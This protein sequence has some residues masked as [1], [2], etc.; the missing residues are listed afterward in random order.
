MGVTEY[1]MNGVR[2]A[3]IPISCR[4]E[5]PICG[6]RKGRC[7]QFINTETGVIEKIR[8]KYRESTKPSNGWYIHDLINKNNGELT[9]ANQLKVDVN[10]IKE[11]IVKRE[12]SQEDLILWDKVYRKMRTSFKKII[13]DYLYPEHKKNLMDRGLSEKEIENMEFFSVP[14][15][16]KISYDG[17]VCK[18]TTALSKELCKDFKPEKLIKVPGFKV[19][20]KDNKKFVTIK[21]LFYEKPNFYDIDGYFVPYHNAEGLLVG[22]QYRIC[23]NVET[24]VRYRWY[25]SKEVTCGSPIDYYVPMHLKYQ[26]Y[27]L[28]TEGG[29]KAKITASKMQIRT[30]GEA[31][32]SNY[33]NTLNT[34]Q[35]IEKLEN[36]KYKIILALDMD[37]Y[38]NEEVM[39]AEIKTVA[40][41]KAAGY[42]VT[43]LE[44]SELDG[45]G[46]DDK[47]Q[48]SSIK[49]FRY[50][51]V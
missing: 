14:R 47:L 19:I 46:I 15:N 23:N 24:K 4:E 45:K 35:K 2:Y 13:G 6:S 16:E 38:K 1:V 49:G 36:K 26:N 10:K 40:L 41:L 5:C 37:K 42:S 30:L 48:S 3:W 28:I 31:G 12:I 8:C 11:E 39:K 29:L 9:S 7:S 21:N 20:E 51:A 22:M 43:I 50:L 44:W 18:L 34:L 32:V 17:Y 27:I 33:R 25:T